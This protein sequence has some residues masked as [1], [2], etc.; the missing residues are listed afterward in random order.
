MTEYVDIVCRQ[1][2]NECISEVEWIAAKV[3]RLLLLARQEKVWE[4]PTA[5]PLAVD[6]VISSKF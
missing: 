4:T 5:L 3:K 2:S 1:T 6:T